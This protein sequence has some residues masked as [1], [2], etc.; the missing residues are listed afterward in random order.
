MP[1]IENRFTLNIGPLAALAL[2][3]RL[4]IPD[5]TGIEAI[6]LG[7]SDDM[8]ETDI[9]AALRSHWENETTD[10]DKSHELYHDHAVLEFPQSRERFEGKANFLAW[11]RIYPASLEFKIM[12]IRGQG[13]LWVAENQIR[14]DGGPWNYGCSILEFRGDKVARETIYITQ[15]WDAPDWRAPWRSDWKEETL[16]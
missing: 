13:S 5:G 15:A 12:R 2:G 11:R 3:C 16:G 8:D 4:T 9:L 6:V 14:Y 1:P 10:I 7:A